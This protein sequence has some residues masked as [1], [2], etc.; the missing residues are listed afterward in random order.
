M[1]MQGKDNSV[2]SSSSGMPGSLAGIQYTEGVM[3]VTSCHS[4]TLSTTSMH[5]EQVIT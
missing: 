2:F 3:P 1:M 4:S 5:T